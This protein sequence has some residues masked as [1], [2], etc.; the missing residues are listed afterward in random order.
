MTQEVPAGG[1]L[2]DATD[3]RRA[4][5]ADRPDHGS[6]N[7]LVYDGRADP[8]PQAVEEPASEPTADVAKAHRSLG[9]A[10]SLVTE[11][12][13][14]IRR[15][16]E[17]VSEAQLSIAQAAI[18]DPDRQHSHLQQ[19][20]RM[21]GS[22]LNSSNDVT[23]DLSRITSCLS[24]TERYLERA[25]RHSA[26]DPDAERWIKPQVDAVRELLVVS[27]RLLAAAGV[28]MSEAHVG[29]QRAIG[30]SG[31]GMKA[32]QSTDLVSD[33]LARADENVRA[34][35]L[36]VEQ[37]YGASTRVADTAADLDAAT[38]SR[39]AAAQLHSPMPS[40]QQGP[41]PGVAR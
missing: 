17:E 19:A 13:P 23:R 1:R 14:A 32:H 16:I 26:A 40:T 8:W 33:S 35:D 29:A 22:I 10:R 12:Q 31:Y 18:C 15:L 7:A 34:V 5:A 11:A 38:R 4:L 21:F 28:H 20:G 24:E 25:S 41:N 2:G 36:V 9:Q 39:M 3:L 6:M 27:Q 37:A 30:L